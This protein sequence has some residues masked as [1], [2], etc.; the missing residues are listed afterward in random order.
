MPCAVQGSDTTRPLSTSGQSNRS[1]RKLMGKN[2]LR[3]ETGLYIQSA[4]SE[5][6]CSMLKTF[7]P[8]LNGEEGGQL[9]LYPLWVPGTSPTC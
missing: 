6:L 7:C 1:L 5:N 2:P 9:G 8:W 4:I 3:V